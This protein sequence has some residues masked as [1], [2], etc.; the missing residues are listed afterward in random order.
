MTGS[1]RALTG[2]FDVLPLP[3]LTATAAGEQLARQRHLVPPPA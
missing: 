3:A 1:Q 2:E